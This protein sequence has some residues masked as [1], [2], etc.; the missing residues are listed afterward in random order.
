MARPKGHRF[1]GLA[2][3]G[4][5]AGLLALLAFGAARWTAQVIFEDWPHLEDEVAY[6]WQAQAATRG[7]LFV[8]SPPYPQWF[9]IPFVIDDAQGRRF[10]KYPP[11][12]PATLALGMR[13]GRPTWV[14][15]FWAAVSVVLLY[16]IGH[17]LE[18]PALGLLAATLA[19]TSPFFW[20]NSG[21]LLSHPT[22]WVLSL[23]LAWAWL[24]LAQTPPPGR[25]RAWAAA[26]IAGLASL[27][28]LLTRPWT[29][30]ALL[31]LFLPGYA[32][33]FLR[34]P[35][36]RAPILS[37]AAWLGLG[38]GLY[39][40]WQYVLTGSPWR[41]PYTLWWPYDRIGFGPGHG[42]LPEGHNLHQAWVNTKFSLYVGNADLL[43]WFRW[44]WLFLPLGWW[45]ARRRP[46]AWPV[47]LAYPS[48]VLFYL[49]YWVSAWLYGPR[50]YYEGLHSW[51]LLTAWGI[52]TVVRGIQRIP[53][54]NLRRGLWAGLSGGLLFLVLANLLY[55]LPGRL[56]MMHGLYGMTPRRVQVFLQ[57]EAQDLTPALVLV[58]G[59][60]RWMDYA[61]Y[62]PLQDPWLQTPWVFAIDPGRWPDRRALAAAFPGR[63]RVLYAPRQDPWLLAIWVDPA[64]VPQGEP[65]E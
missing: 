7:A 50:Y 22:A 33:L 16:W 6:W 26:T 64:P 19:L 20:L 37:F 4:I 62:V 2:R 43:G 27:G 14:N 24:V 57:P 23:A 60:E 55:Y 35:A 18:G 32:V 47:L 36:L 41:N 65:K 10:G 54:R 1:R 34:R 21:S 11:G 52:L 46:A 53:F 30:V 44:S 5:L 49:A 15:P 17:R 3:P 9:L 38:L 25:A 61:V 13:V 31:A 42:V 48:L 63:N 12:W 45:P 58:Q 56:A 59:V 51:L 8:P 28:L 29:G 40:L 39:A